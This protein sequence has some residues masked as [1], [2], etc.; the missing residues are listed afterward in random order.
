MDLVRSILL[1]LE[2]ETY[3]GTPVSIAIKDHSNEEIVYH[4]ML[5]SEAGLIEALELGFGEINWMPIRLTW[6]GHEFLEAARDEKRWKKA[7]KTMDTKG[8]G[9]VF[10]ILEELLMSMMRSDLDAAV[11]PGGKRTKENANASPKV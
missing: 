11:G 8:G 2:K 5:L 3:G 10:A 4:V 1:E 9:V 6:A 7:L